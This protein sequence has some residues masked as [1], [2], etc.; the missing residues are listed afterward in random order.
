MTSRTRAIVVG[1]AA[2]LLLLAVSAAL[3]AGPP[4][5]SPTPV[6]TEPTSTIPSSVREDATTGTLSRASD[7]FTARPGY[8]GP[9]FL[10]TLSGRAVVLTDTVRIA[11]GADWSA[12]GLIRNETANV[13][14][15]AQ[16]TAHLFD[17]GHQELGSA[18]ATVPLTALRAGEPA[19]FHIHADV[20][21]TLV[22]SVEWTVTYRPI[23]RM[24]A[25][26]SSSASST[27]ED[28]LR[29]MEFSVF[30]QRPY[31]YAD[32]RYG[33]PQND[34][35]NG[36]YPYVVFGE[37]HN[38]GTQPIEAARVLAAWLDAAGGVINVDWLT[39][40]PPEQNAPPRASTAL[41]AD[42]YADFIYRNS[43]PIIAPRLSDARV[44]LWGVDSVR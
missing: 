11:P 21:S 24:A 15:N 28:A 44:V 14:R 31:G 23:P 27:S 35:A 17:A 40:L 7:G 4:G 38:S 22:A 19:P 43:D 8:V 33:Y 3:Q 32:R 5:Q 2:L 29:T 39:I 6:A 20:T 26:S 18:E 30:W 25:E 9:D 36:P 16:V 13:I 34:P 1:T 42:G 10:G 41:P 37:I 12:D